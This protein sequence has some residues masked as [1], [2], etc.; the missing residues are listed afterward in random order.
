MKAIRVN[1]NNEQEE[2]VLLS[3]LD[4]LNYDYEPQ[5]SSND[6][7]LISQALE[8]SNRDH[9]EGNTSSHED[10]MNRIKTRYDL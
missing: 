7:L 3:I 6:E 9:E 8:S 10:V 2:K 4:S 1:F 5:Y